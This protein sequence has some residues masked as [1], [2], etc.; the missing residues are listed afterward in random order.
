[1]L[2]KQT[3]LEK[4]KNLTDIQFS[5]SWSSNPYCNLAV[6]PQHLNTLAWE[7]S[8]PCRPQGISRSFIEQVATQDWLGLIKAETGV[9]HP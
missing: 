2:I 5:H 6:T 3:S 9:L 8:S 4:K 1:M 7:A